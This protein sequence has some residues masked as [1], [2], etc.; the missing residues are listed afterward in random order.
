MLCFSQKI[1]CM[2]DTF[3]L[4]LPAELVVL[5]AC[6]TARGEKVKGETLPLSR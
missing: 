1:L 5:N 6:E 4:K 2:H 3:N